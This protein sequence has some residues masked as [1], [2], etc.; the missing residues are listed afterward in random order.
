LSLEFLGLLGAGTSPTAAKNWGLAFLVL[1]VLY[2]VHAMVSG[3]EIDPTPR[4]T[5]CRYNL[6]GNVSG[7]CP[8]CGTPVDF[9][10]IEAIVMRIKSAN[11]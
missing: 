7:V 6:T 5:K 8:E 10:S 2:L 4:C 1:G 9:S 3:R 11:R